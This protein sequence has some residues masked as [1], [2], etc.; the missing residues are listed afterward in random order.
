MPLR[1][2]LIV[3]GV[4]LLGAGFFVGRGLLH[5]RAVARLSDRGRH[6]DE[7]LYRQLAGFPGAV[8]IRRSTGGLVT[9]EECFPYKYT[10]TVQFRLPAAT[11]PDAVFTFYSVHLPAG[12]RMTTSSAD[13]P[14]PTSGSSTPPFPKKFVTFRALITNNGKVVGLNVSL[15]NDGTPI[16]MFFRGEAALGCVIGLS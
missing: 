8:E 4:A 6:E 13:C 9:C 3:L 16:L 2:F 1:G 11:T 15:L 14:V 10:E 7:V 12:W 5:Q